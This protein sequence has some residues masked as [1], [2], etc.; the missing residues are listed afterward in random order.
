MKKKNFAV[1]AA[2]LLVISIIISGCGADETVSEVEGEGGYDIF[3]TNILTTETVT[4]PKF[5]ADDKLIALT[6]DDGPNPTHTNRILDI[7]EENGA[8]ATF[9]VVGY[10]IEDN[11]E[12]IKRAQAMGC[13]IGNHTADHKILTKCDSATI[14]SQVKTPNDMI[15]NLTGVEM[16]LFRAPGGAFKG[17]KSEIGMPLIQWSIDTEDWK[18][19]D[20]AHKNRT[21]SERNAELRR[22]ADEV[23]QGAEKG[24]IVLMHDIY[25]FTADLCE[26]IIPELVEKGFKLVTVSEMYEAYG[27]ELDNGTVY[28]SIK[29]EEPTSAPAAANNSSDVV[30]TAGEYTVRTNGGTLNVRAEPAQ[31]TTILEKLSNGDKVDVIKAVKGWALVKTE[32]S[33]G[34]VNSAYLVKN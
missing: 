30:L 34:W 24:D 15:K 11:I 25:N 5:T 19:K 14:H 9:F 27:E 29:F 16:K 6:F 23:V 8:T 20:A 4:E 10:N 13:E 3:D 31:E 32:S 2:L 1:F 7:L 28:Y 22:I 17:V 26:L 33:I 12:T 21:E 18:S